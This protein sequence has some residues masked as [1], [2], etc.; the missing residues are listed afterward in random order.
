MGGSLRK[1]TIISSVLVYIGFGIG[2]L[3]TWLFTQ[4]GGSFTPD[5]YALTRLFF[6][7]GQLFCCFA[8]LSILQVVYKFYPFYKDNLPTR[9]IDLFTRAFIIVVIGCILTSVGGYV[10]EPV[11]V[12][13]YSEKSMLFV[14][15][16]HWVLIFGIGFTFF[17]LF[18][19]FSWLLHK[20][21]LSSFLKETGIRIITT[22]F[23]LLYYFKL[24]TFQH[25]IFLFSSM[26][27]IAAAIL[28]YFLL[29]SGNLPIAFSVSRVSKKF[30]KQMFKMQ[31]FMFGGFTV[32]TIG[33]NIDAIIIASVAGLKQTGIYTLA[34]YAANLIQVPQRSIQ[35]VS[36]GVVT[37]AWKD[38]NY[39]EINRIYSRSTINMLLLGLFIFGNIWLNVADG[40]NV[41]HI[42]DDFKA[43]LQAI[44]IIGCIRIVDAG[45]GINQTI[46]AASNKWVF[47]FYTG[48]GMLALRIVLAYILVSKYGFIGSAYAELISLTLYNF[49]RYEFLR[50]VFNMQP[51]SLKTL[52]ALL[53]GVASYY[54]TYVVLNSL[55]GWPGIITRTAAF[56]VLLIGGTMMLK[57]TPDASQL[58]D[59]L[60]KRFAGK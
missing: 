20:A 44:F 25:F 7:V 60:K 16:Y 21:I 39:K 26:F 4:K 19:S 5:Q 12:R 46:I 49:I 27:F 9:E 57:L 8:T 11:I 2:A 31:A 35:A 53:L 32:I 54:A 29:K 41:L 30:K 14:N 33:Q 38:K 37:Q 55:T 23:I 17:T 58:F 10:F 52:Y 47:E 1:Q 34:A 36:T 15:Y 18:E 45:T 40:L 56:S 6:D 3:N 24:V 13:K 22:I 28:L 59:N 42:Q 50:R 51:F 48:I 43:G